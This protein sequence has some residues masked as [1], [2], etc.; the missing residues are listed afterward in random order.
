MAPPKRK[1][2][3]ASESSGRSNKL[4]KQQIADDDA[5]IRALEKKLG[6]KN[7][8]SVPKSFKDDGLEDLFGADFDASEEETEEQSKQKAEYDA[9]LAAKR[10]KASG[11]KA[12]APEPVSEDEGEEDGFEG[13]SDEEGL[14]GEEEDEGDFDE[15][16]DEDEDKHEDGGEEGLGMDDDELDSNDFD[17]DGDDS[18][19][20][21]EDGEDASDNE[22]AAPKVRENPYVAPTE[23][24]VVGKYIPPSLRKAALGISET[25]MRLQRQLQGYLNRLSESNMLGIL[26][27]VEKIYADHARGDANNALIEALMMQVCNPATL[28]DTFYV[29]T[30]GFAAAVYKVVGESFGSQLVT[31]V[32]ELFQKEY[33]VAKNTEGQAS[34]ATSN[35]LTFMSEL[36]VFQV[37]GCNMIFD[38][39]RLLLDNITELSTELILRIVRMAGKY[40]RKDDPQALK[41]IVS[42]LGSPAAAN[43]NKEISVRTKF[44]IETITDLKNNKLKAGVQESAVVADHVSRMRRLL[45]SMNSRR[46]A[47]NGPM[48]IGLR[49]IALA[50]TKGKWWLTGASFADPRK[51]AA[52]AEASATLSA[53]KKSTLPTLEDDG[54][55]STDSEDYEFWLPENKLRQLAIEHGLKKDVQQTIMIAIAGAANLN[56]AVVHFR[57]LNLNKTH[58]CEV[59]LVLMTCASS[60]HP[61]NPFYAAVAK[62]LSSDGRIRYAFKS[63]LLSVFRRLGESLFDEEEEEDDDTLGLDDTRLESIGKFVGTL[64]VDGSM[65]IQCLKAIDFPTM[66]KKSGV[67]VRQILKSVFTE[68]HKAG[69]VKDHHGNR[70]GPEETL[71]K[72]LKD[73]EGTGLVAGLQF[74]F[75]KMLKAGDLKKSEKETCKLARSLLEQQNM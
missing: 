31:K 69:K 27:D 22:P 3:E 68:A 54:Y 72:V 30:A 8:K 5:T 13:F 25:T 52:A 24:R 18:D 32:I 48:R 4:L 74:L 66:Q 63:Q 7:R 36:Y 38:F 70:R 65:S 2:G 23:G 73:T 28:P 26:K 44:M 19:H 45:G 62:K 55:A 67:L 61:Y 37:V 40:I 21:D 57:K 41:D 17:E 35:L 51:A 29:L 64:I 15:D 58:R 16:E 20:D 50:D 43:D 33:E 60:E 9:W 75:A 12:P 59:A 53:A 34:K 14:E 46:L 42:A 1:Y 6:I 49:D 10:A 39:I 56:D 71:R 11:G 47:A